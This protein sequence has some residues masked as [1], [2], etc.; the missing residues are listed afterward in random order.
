MGQTCRPKTADTPRMAPSS[1]ISLAP[2][3][4]SSAGWKSSLTVPCSSASLVFSTLAAAAGLSP[5]VIYHG[6]TMPNAAADL[7]CMQQQHAPAPP[8]SAR[9][10][11]S[12]TV[13]CS[14]ASRA[15]TT[16]AAAHH[17]LLSKL[18]RISFSLLSF[19]C[20]KGCPTRGMYS[21]VAAAYAPRPI[22]QSGHFII[23]SLMPYM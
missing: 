23:D 22:E 15:F 19:P 20:P 14:S 18:V 5:S 16:L 1:T 6:H 11:I 4:P 17:R 3:P 10:K 13:P 21:S 7:P 9:W 8:S 2:A 12:L